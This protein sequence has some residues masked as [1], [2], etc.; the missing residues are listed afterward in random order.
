MAER[1]I[2]Q[3]PTTGF[4][5]VIQSFDPSHP[6]N[7]DKTVGELC[8]WYQQSP[9]TAFKIGYLKQRAKDTRLKVTQTRP[10]DGFS[11]SWR[12]WFGT[13]KRKG[14]GYAGGIKLR[15]DKTEFAVRPH[16]LFLIVRG[17]VPPPNFECHHVCN[18]GSNG[19]VGN[20]FEEGPPYHVVP[21][22]AEVNASAKSKQCWGLTS[23]PCVGHK[24]KSNRMWPPC[25][26]VPMQ[27]TPTELAWPSS[28]TSLKR[29][30]EELTSELE[31]LENKKV[32]IL[33]SIKRMQEQ[34]Q[35]MSDFES[36]DE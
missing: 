11:S 20:P 6:A 28:K 12:C 30:I 35:D 8:P 2:A 3:N 7:D 32:A 25:P 9:V 31:L 14:D 4:Y 18:N 17:Y 34:L 27:Q 13:W 22:P 19:C 16:I 33:A 21:V 24:D 36:D 26:P 29:K 1:T 5:H 15:Q 10:T 23:T